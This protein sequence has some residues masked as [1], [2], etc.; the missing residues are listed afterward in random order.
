M[1]GKPICPE[2]LCNSQAA[3]ASELEQGCTL[4]SWGDA[5]CR[6]V[7][8]VKTTR[9]FTQLSLFTRHDATVALAT[10]TSLCRSIKSRSVSR[11]WPSRF[12]SLSVLVVLCRPLS[13]SLFRS[14]MSS[15]G[16][17]RFNRQ[18]YSKGFQENVLAFSFKDVRSL[19]RPAVVYSFTVQLLK[20]VLI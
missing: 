18:T 2:H 16:S 13:L 9:Q 14:A 3:Q 12:I 7:D 5:R 20:T 1:S 8:C 17:Q 4:V 6:R 11:V 19:I 15:Y 10:V